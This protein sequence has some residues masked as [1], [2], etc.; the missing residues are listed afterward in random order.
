MED[1]PIPM[2]EHKVVQLDTARLLRDVREIKV[3]KAKATGLTTELRLPPHDS[4]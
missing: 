4:L 3:E 1:D 2:I